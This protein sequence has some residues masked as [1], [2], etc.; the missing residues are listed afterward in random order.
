MTSLSV[1]SQD[2]ADFFGPMEMGN[3]GDWL[4][5]YDLFGLQ[6]GYAWDSEGTWMS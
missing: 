5:N 6:C 1:P 3:H 4:M 2:L